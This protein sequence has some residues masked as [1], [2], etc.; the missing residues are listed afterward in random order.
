VCKLAVIENVLVGFAELTLDGHV[1]CMYVH[2]DYQGKSVARSL[3][4]EL[5]QIAEERNYEVLSTEASITAKPFFEKH[6]FNVTQ[7]K[8]KLYNGKEFTNYKMIKQL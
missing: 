7:I 5:L 3:L 8:R 4:N 2:K 1:D 6:G